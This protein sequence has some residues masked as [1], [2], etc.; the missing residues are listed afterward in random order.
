MDSSPTP[1]QRETQY[2]AISG[3]PAATR[4]T[5]SS[6]NAPL[7]SRSPELLADER[8]EVVHLQGAE[9]FVGWQARAALLVSDAMLIALDALGA[10]QFVQE[11]LVRQVAFGCFER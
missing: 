9:G 10:L 2:A 1:N 3:L 6:R 11:G 5:A 8:R 4:L 7:R